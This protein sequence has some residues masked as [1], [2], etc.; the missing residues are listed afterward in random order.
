MSEKF[1]VVSEEELERLVIDA[2]NTG[3]NTSALYGP[4]GSEAA[5]RA[6]EVPVWATHFVGKIDDGEH[7]VETHQEIHKK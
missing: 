4:N 2:L 7:W 5:C 1:Y 3:Y 6:R